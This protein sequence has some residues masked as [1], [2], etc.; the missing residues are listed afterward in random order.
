MPA[1]SASEQRLFGQAHAYKSGKLKKKDIN[2]KYFEKIK[3]LANS[4][5]D[6]KLKDF[7]ETSHKNLPE[8]VSE[9][10][11]MTFEKFIQQL[12]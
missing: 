4:M 2:P 9:N 6:K 5:S 1:R 12:K 10:Y 8:K 11:V 7:A 3:K